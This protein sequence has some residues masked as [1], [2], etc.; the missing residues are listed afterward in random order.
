MREHIPYGRQHID[1]SDVETVVSVLRSDWLTQGPAVDKFEVALAEFCGA[2]YAVAVSNA[3]AALHLSCLAL[4]LKTGDNLWTSPNTFVA[5]AN[6]ALYCGAG[7]DFVDIDPV[8]YNMSASVLKEK[9][10]KAKKDSR[11]P[12]VLVPVHHSGQSCDME[13]ISRIC[14]DYGVKVLEDASHS[15]GA[16]YQ[17][18]KVGDCQHSDLCV[19]SFHPVKIMT[20]GEGGAIT[21]NDKLLYEKL[22]RLRSHG[23][24]RDPSMMKDAPHGPWYYAQID[25]GYNYRLTDL[26]AALGT[27]Q[28]KKVDG[29]VD[30]RH[31]I[32]DRYDRELAALP[33]QLPVREKG[34]RSA[35]HLYVVR[36]RKNAHVSHLELFQ[37]LR[38]AEIGVNLHYI[39]VYLQPYYQAMGFK[40]GH[41]PEAEKYYAEAVSLPMYFGLTPTSQD[42]VI[43]TLREILS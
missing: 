41:C 37:K 13:E 18:R 38:A 5:S 33:L 26:Q 1:D 24:T 6:C 11:L 43:R 28:L 9:L 19:F 27:N 40:A 2:K 7:V 34:S 17:G 42:R 35:L 10:A 36:L 20:T 4:G 32:A 25:L 39:P 16:S 12:A 3:T 22:L 21:T 15:I 14:R 29:F 30:R 23:I 8:S 31:E